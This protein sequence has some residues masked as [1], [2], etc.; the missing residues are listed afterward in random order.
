ML[1]ELVN[2]LRN[3]LMLAPARAPASVCPM[4]IPASYTDDAAGCGGFLLQVSLFIEMQP[5][6][7]TTKQSKVA[8]LISLL[9]GKALLWVKVIW[10]AQSVI[11]NSYIVFSKHFKKVIGV[12]ADREDFRIRDMHP[13]FNLGSLEC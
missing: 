8:F 12:A 9:G 5:Q 6:K 10:N 13:D 3:T 1:E 7:F 11:I 2:T 4:A